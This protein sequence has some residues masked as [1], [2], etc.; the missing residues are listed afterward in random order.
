MN[1]FQAITTRKSIRKFSDKP[2]DDKL[3][4]VMLYAATH[5]PSAGNLQEWEFVVVEDQ[6]IKE[7]LANA[8]LKQKQIADAPI[9]IVV[10][11]DLDRVSDKYGKRGE[12]LYAVQ[13]TSAATMNMLLAA[14]ALGLGTNWISAF[15]EEEVK[16]I[17]DLPDN[18]RPLVIVAVGYPAEEPEKLSR[19]PFEDITYLNKY[20]NKIFLEFEP[21]A[22]A[23][24]K[25]I[26]A[27]VEKYKEGKPKK[28]FDFAELL[29]RLA[30]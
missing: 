29:K 25:Q 30:K 8:A 28:K 20:G 1:I 27:L 4:G 14:T 26:R 2:V 7:R 3:I 19:S 22:T 23:L 11:A 9:D 16:G 15:D 10:C 6:K 5:A 18:V 12:I 17:L 13:D 21:L 24:E